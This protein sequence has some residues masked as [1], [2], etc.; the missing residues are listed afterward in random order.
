MLLAHCSHLQEFN[1]V[2]REDTW[3][4]MEPFLSSPAPILEELGLTNFGTDSNL[5]VALFRGRADRLRKISIYNYN[6]AWTCFPP[7]PLRILAVEMW[8]NTGEP[9][10]HQ[11]PD[12][13]LDLLATL[14]AL[15]VLSLEHCLP[16]SSVYTDTLPVTLLHIAEVTFAGR[17]HDVLAALDHV[18]FPASAKLK[19]DCFST[20]FTENECMTAFSFG[21]AHLKSRGAVAIRT[22]EIYNHQIWAT[23]VSSVGVALH[24]C[25]PIS[26]FLMPDLS[27]SLSWPT[28]LEEVNGISLSV[29]RQF[30]GAFPLKDVQTLSLD[31]ACPEW[32]TTESWHEIF[33]QCGS[34]L[35]LS[36]KGDGYPRLPCSD[37][38]GRFFF[39]K[40]KS[41]QIDQA[42]FNEYYKFGRT[43]FDVLETALRQRRS[44]MNMAVEMLALNL[45][46]GDA[47]QAA[48]LEEQVGE[49]DRSGMMENP[50][51]YPG[52]M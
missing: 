7:S 52:Y 23:D 1:V 26:T 48:A 21:A 20:A 34:L 40:L 47:D 29:L 30:A 24:E 37:A 4:T 2:R 9:A 11:R 16:P 15:E 43:A 12:F 10:P 3:K 49:L 36:V 35:H 38:D 25:L 33:G 28:L 18:K 44:T 42:N 5:P 31:L 32:T 50:E 39:P 6:F 27:F 41:L 45:C 51:D 8:R 17:V 19:L 46:R 13:F 22:L 14:P